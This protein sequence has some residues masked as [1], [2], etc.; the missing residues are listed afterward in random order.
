MH[1][2]TPKRRCDAH[3]FIVLRDLS[4]KGMVSEDLFKFYVISYFGRKFTNDLNEYI[5]K[6]LDS[7]IMAR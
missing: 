7:H 3:N 6:K 5:V 2:K 1:L 4:N